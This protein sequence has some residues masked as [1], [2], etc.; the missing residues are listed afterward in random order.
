[1]W[2]TLKEKSNPHKKGSA[3]QSSCDIYVKLKIFSIKE[4]ICYKEKI[5]MINFIHPSASGIKH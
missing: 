1:M 4:I 3:Q 5:Q 2:K